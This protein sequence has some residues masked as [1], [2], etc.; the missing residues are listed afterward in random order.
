[1]TPGKIGAEKVK[2][3]AAAIVGSK[4]AKCCLGGRLKDQIILHRRDSQTTKEF[5]RTK[6]HESSQVNKAKE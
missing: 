5:E 2:G 6:N 1:L 4:V 3:A